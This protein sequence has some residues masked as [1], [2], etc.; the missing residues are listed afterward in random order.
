MNNI[1]NLKEELFTVDRQFS[2]LSK[3]MGMAHAFDF[4]MAD[5]ATMLRNGVPPVVGREAI[6]KL[7]ENTPEGTQLIWEP[8]FADI[9]ASGDLGY[10]I[11][12][13]E[14]S[15]TDSAGETATAHGYYISVWKK[16]PNGSW[17]FVFDTGTTGPK[18]EE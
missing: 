3:Q 9:A 6:N 4:Y 8:E 5:S 1:E 14:Y 13:W 10:T 18:E 16:Q 17:K 12:R 11:G 15:T 2:E 7:F